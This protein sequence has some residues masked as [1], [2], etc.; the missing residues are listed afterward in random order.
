[1]DAER[2]QHVADKSAAIEA[3]IA[4]IPSQIQRRIAGEG[5]SL[6]DSIALCPELG[7]APA[8]TR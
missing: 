8:V 7:E 5:L 3:I 2:A 1:M 4:N 6:D